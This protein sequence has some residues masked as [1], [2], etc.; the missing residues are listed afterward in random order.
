MAFLE[1]Q[2][3]KCLNN[4]AEWSTKNGFKFSKSKT[5][6]MHFCN[7]RNLHPDPELSLENTPIPVVTETKFLGIIFD[8]KLSFKP[9]IKYLKQKCQSSLNLLKVVSHMNWGGDSV[10]LLRLY[11]A[12]IRSKLDYGCAVYG[13]ARPSY[14]KCPNTVQNDA[15][16]LALGAYRT[17]PIE[18]LE[19]EAG[20]PP[21]NLRRKKIS[22]TFAMKQRANPTNPVNDTIF[23]PNFEPIYEKKPDSIPPFSLRVADDSKRVCPHPSYI[24][25]FKTTRAPP[26]TLIKP[27]VNMDLAALSK[28]ETDSLV[29][30][31]KFNEI[32]AG[33]IDHEHIYTDGSKKVTG[34]EPPS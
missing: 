27:E 18:S 31:S 23:T 28:A 26:W 24:S 32:K 5:V 20:I 13:A 10:T 1:R 17:S 9:H 12:L 11:K 30:R 34:W 4:L 33:V 22:L 8:N 3:Q 29:Y 16:R 6:A 21:L 25:I 2:L 19:V 15:L 7:K 14:L